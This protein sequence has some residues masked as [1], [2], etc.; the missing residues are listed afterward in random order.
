MRMEQFTKNAPLLETLP[1]IK[2]R[3]L[4]LLHTIS[5]QKIDNVHYRLSSVDSENQTLILHVIRKNIFIKQSFAEI[6]ANPALIS[7]FNPEE[8]CWIGIYYG[9][10]LHSAAH[11]KTHLKNIKKACYLL[12]YHHG[13]YKIMSEHR[14]GKITCLHTKTRTT[15]CVDPLSIAKD[16]IF[17]R[18]F[19]AT[20]ACYIG[21]LAGIK[22][23]KS[24]NKEESLSS[25]PFLRLVK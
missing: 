17:I 10:A 23:D 11:G 4:Q 5:F 3:L 2:K 21:M 8:A 1:L 24:E 18:Q 20:Q 6:I 9:K 22:L 13:A 14:D 15:V 7:G 12:H 25:V 16:S 19:D